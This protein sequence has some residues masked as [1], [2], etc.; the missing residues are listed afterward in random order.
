MKRKG[1]LQFIYALMISIVV[2][3]CGGGGGDSS[4]QSVSD[5]SAKGT[6]NLVLKDETNSRQFE[7]SPVEVTQGLSR[8]S[9][10]VFKNTTASSL[11]YAEGQSRNGDLSPKGATTNEPA[12][13]LKLDKFT[14]SGVGPEGAT[15][16]V[17][18]NGRG[19][20]QIQGLLNGEWT[21]TVSAKDGSGKEFARGQ[22]NVFVRADET[23]AAIINLSLEEGN[24]SF[25][26]EVSW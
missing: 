20:R 16:T 3:A 13:D 25:D 9:N 19:G 11:D 5:T 21:I 6:L 12:L 10:G 22:Q 2:T 8:S 26:F 24:G 15:F 18:V 14:I 7:S 23:T 1:I 4:N 17:D